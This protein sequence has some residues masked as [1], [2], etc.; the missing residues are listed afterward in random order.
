RVARN[1]VVNAKP[2]TVG[3]DRDAVVD[4]VLRFSHEIE[5]GNITAQKRSGRCWAFAALNRMRLDCMEAMDLDEFEFSQ[6]Y[7]MFWDK[8]EKA[9]YFLENILRTVDVPTDSRLFMWLVD[10]PVNDAGQWDMLVNLVEKYG[11]VPKETYPESK[12]SSSTHRMNSHLTEK[13]REWASELR[14]RHEN[15]ESLAELRERKSEM[16][17]TV[18]RILAI[19][20]GEP[21]ASFEWSWR[22]SDDEFHDRGEMT[23]LEFVDEFVDLEF[24]DYVS[25]IHC[26][27][28]DKPFD[29]TYT[30]DYL[31]N[32]PEGQP[33]RYLNTDIEIVK[34]ATRQSLEDEE[35]VWFGCDV[36]KQ[37]HRGE[38]IL[39]LDTFEFDV[40]YDTDFGM[41]KGQR[42][43]FGHSQMTHA[44]LFTSVHIRDDQPVRWKVEN[45]W[46]KDAG[47]KG[48]LVMSD[49][50]FDEYL[51]QVVVPKDYVPDETLAALDEDPTVLPPWDP[52]GALAT[53]RR[54]K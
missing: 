39:D 32:V 13:L 42:V 35:A 49:D 52:M 33:I 15:G 31:G 10:D 50:W 54:K 38:G 27:T 7:V 47:Q 12:S 22:D 5:S 43:E 1:A 2:S 11:L 25:L 36:G 45:S 41:D 53:R 21:P 19:H 40:L 16:L 6:A 29:R 34:R 8:L 48:F 44:M 26:P 14:T 3:L 28:D 9:N 51:F 18:Y 23:P 4:N 17:E 24:D 20:N 37:L 30:I 46:G